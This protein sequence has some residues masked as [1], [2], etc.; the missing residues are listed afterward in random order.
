MAGNLLAGNFTK[1]PQVFVL[2]PGKVSQ[3]S[4]QF[5]P[6]P[7]KAFFPLSWGEKNKTKPYCINSSR[8]RNLQVKSTPLP[9]P[10]QFRTS[11]LPLKE[12]EQ[13]VDTTYLR[14]STTTASAP[15]SS[16][17]SPR[18]PMRSVIIKG[19]PA[20]LLELEFLPTLSSS[21]LLCRQQD[22][23]VSESWDTDLYWPKSGQ[24]R[25]KNASS[26]LGMTNTESSHS[27]SSNKTIS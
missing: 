1:C 5:S 25:E 4:D 22:L 9:I 11:C 19:N 8:R 2:L 14:I 18:V 16:R 12:H 20:S 6:F 7:L 21:C 3:G 13:A 27:L 10:L 23:I 24:Q 26:R 17:T 15:P